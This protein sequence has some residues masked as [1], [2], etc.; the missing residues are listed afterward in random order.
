M[1]NIILYR[2]QVP[3]ANGSN[4]FA[5]YLRNCREEFYLKFHL[6]R[7]RCRD[8]NLHRRGIKTAR[9][10]V[11]LFK[12]YGTL[13]DEPR[14]LRVETEVSWK[15]PSKRYW[16][17][18]AFTILLLPNLPVTFSATASSGPSRTKR[19]KT[20]SALQ[21]VYERNERAR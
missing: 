3:S 11:V 10:I 15:L 13:G 5:A 8:I 21:D 18:V 4:S 1:W 2:L 9:N 12:T 16:H 14:A 19:E 7:I 17:L 6:R 20:N